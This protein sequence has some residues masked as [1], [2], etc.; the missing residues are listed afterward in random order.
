MY[1]NYSAGIGFTCLII[2]GFLFLALGLYLEQV[3]PSEY[4]THKHPL[5]CCMRSTYPCCRRRE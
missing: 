4:G 3:L 2:G 5:F 1:G